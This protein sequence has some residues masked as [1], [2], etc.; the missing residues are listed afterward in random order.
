MAAAIETA[1]IAATGTTSGDVD[2]PVTYAVF[3]LIEAPAVLTGTVAVHGS[4]DGTAFKALYRA[5]GT[6]VTVPANAIIRVDVEGLDALR[7][8]SSG[9]EA[10]QRDFTVQIES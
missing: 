6:A 10:A 7:L 8:V 2:I 1:T 4:R 3:A 5:D 9:A